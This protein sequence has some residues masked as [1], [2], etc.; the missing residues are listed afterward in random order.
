MTKTTESNRFP[1]FS[2]LQFYRAAPAIDQND[3]TTH[4]SLVIALPQFI[5]TLEKQKI[6]KI[7]KESEDERGLHH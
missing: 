5:I 4:T 1:L 3:H 2:K 7:H 6:M